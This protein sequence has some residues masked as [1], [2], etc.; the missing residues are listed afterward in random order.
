M[1]AALETSL[2]QAR[3]VDASANIFRSQRLAPEHVVLL[4]V[5]R[6]RHDL[7]KALLE[8]QEVA[9]IRRDMENGGHAVEFPD[10]GAKVFVH[11]DQYARVLSALEEWSLRSGVELHPRHI[12][13]SSEYER[14]VVEAISSAKRTSVKCRRVGTLTHLYTEDSNVHV[15]VKRTFIHLEIPTSLPSSSSGARTI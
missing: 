11:P 7:R 1:D 6:T 4:E 10:S 14:Q 3:P 13:V 2:A 5:N 8:G 15:E 12:V 9:D